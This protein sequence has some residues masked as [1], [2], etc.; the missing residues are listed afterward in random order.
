MGCLK[1]HE[2]EVP[3]KDALRKLIRTYDKN[4]KFTINYNEFLYLISPKFPEENP[5]SYYYIDKNE[6]FI[7]ILIQEL[8]LIDKLGEITF[9]I[10]NT[11]NFNIFEIF[12][13]IRLFR[14]CNCYKIVH[15]TLQVCQ[16]YC[17]I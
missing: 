8:K 3:C 17:F 15:M 16:T 7:N 1:E 13:I 2:W 9:H 14:A 6:I 5:Q 12:M 10:K 11:R 4:G